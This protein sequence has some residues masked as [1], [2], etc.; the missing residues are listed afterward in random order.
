MIEVDLG[1]WKVDFRKTGTQQNT[2][3]ISSIEDNMLRVN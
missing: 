3:L 1:K 2:K